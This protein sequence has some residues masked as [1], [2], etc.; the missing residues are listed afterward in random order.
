MFLYN[1]LFIVP[2]QLSEVLQ[3]YTAR[4]LRVIGLAYRELQGIDSSSCTFT[5]SFR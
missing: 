2:P 1:L 4:G 3:S 5:R